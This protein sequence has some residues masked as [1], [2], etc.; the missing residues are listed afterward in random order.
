MA[1]LIRAAFAEGILIPPHTNFDDFYTNFDDFYTNF[2]DFYNKATNDDLVS[3]SD[4]MPKLIPQAKTDERVNK[5]EFLTNNNIIP[6]N[7]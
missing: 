6:D 7:K 3:I 2:D 5:N 4:D 1:S